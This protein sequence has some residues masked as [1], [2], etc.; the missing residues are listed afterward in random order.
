MEVLLLA[1]YSTIVCGARMRDARLR[2]G[3]GW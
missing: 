3:N 1:I 2:S